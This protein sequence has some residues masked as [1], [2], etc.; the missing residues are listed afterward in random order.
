[1]W[2]ENATNVQREATAVRTNISR[3]MRWT[4]D[5]AGIRTLVNAILDGKSIEL[6]IDGTITLK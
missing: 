2:Q 6:R 4:E 3:R 1:M 5:A